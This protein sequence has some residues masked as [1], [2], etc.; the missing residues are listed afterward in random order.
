M[1]AADCGATAFTLPI[2]P[3]P[4]PPDTHMRNGGRGARRSTYS[5]STL[6]SSA[7]WGRDLEYQAAETAA[8]SST[9]AVV[10]A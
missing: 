3:P 10:V 7:R 9:A 4:G 2:L 6:E 1:G 8:G 5:C